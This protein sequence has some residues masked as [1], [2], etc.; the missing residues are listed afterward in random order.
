MA[1]KILK[2]K[3]RLLFAVYNALKRIPPREYPSTE[4]IKIVLED[5]LPEFKKHVLEYIVVVRKATAINIRI[6]EFGQEKVQKMVDELNVN[7]RIYNKEHGLDDIE[8]K[9]DKDAITTLT[10]QFK[11]EDAKGQPPI[12]GRSW[13]NNIDEFQYFSDN[14]ESRESSINLSEEDDLIAADLKE[15][16]K[17]K[18]KE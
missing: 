11:R 14:L 2:T 4:E 5:I 10:N 1:S 15:E 12:W 9:L 3:R 8:V 7:W 17:K 13:F 6:E 16:E 18:E